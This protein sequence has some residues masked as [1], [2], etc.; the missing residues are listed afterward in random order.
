MLLHP[1]I[2]EFRLSIILIRLWYRTTLEE[3]GAAEIGSL[4]GGARRLWLNLASGN[5]SGNVYT[6]PRSS[7]TFPW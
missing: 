5:Q 2:N 6:L 3:R 4:V 7:K 1:R